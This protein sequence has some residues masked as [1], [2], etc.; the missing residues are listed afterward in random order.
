MRIHAFQ[1]CRLLR[2]RPLSARPEHSNP[3]F[4]TT[5]KYLQIKAS[6]IDNVTGIWHGAYRW[7]YSQDCLSKGTGQ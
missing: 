5:I 3:L 4:R 2:F 1:T 6:N 7:T